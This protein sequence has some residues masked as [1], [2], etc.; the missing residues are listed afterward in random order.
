MLIARISSQ[1]STDTTLHYSCSFY[2]CVVRCCRYIF[3]INLIC[4]KLEL[5]AR[6]CLVNFLR[7]ARK[8]RKVQIKECV[9]VRLRTRKEIFNVKVVWHANY[10]LKKI[11]VEQCGLNFIYAAVVRIYTIELVFLFALCVMAI[12][13]TPPYTSFHINVMYIYASQM[14]RRRLDNQF[15]PSNAQLLQKKINI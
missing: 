15:L 8:Y 3:I 7:M 14:L 5:R 12:F 6:S 10:K 13:N 2:M 1:H 11:K 9:C 4:G